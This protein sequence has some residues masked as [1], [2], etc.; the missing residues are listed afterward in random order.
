M[1]RHAS[2]KTHIAVRHHP[3]TLIV[4]FRHLVG[5]QRQAGL[6]LHRPLD[7][8]AHCQAGIHPLATSAPV[9]RGT[10]VG[11]RPPCDLQDQ[12]ARA[13]GEI[14]GRMTTRVMRHRWTKILPTASSDNRPILMLT[15]APAHHSL[16]TSH[17]L[18]HHVF[19]APHPIKHSQAVHL[20]ASSV[21]ATFSVPNWTL[22]CLR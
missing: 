15:Q 3:R 21:Q 17:I 11:M 9:T 2:A 13:D 6:P 5:Q 8:E 20:L 22:N 12:A 1:Y 14:M 10:A 18:L 16:Q 7:H 19:R 4:Q